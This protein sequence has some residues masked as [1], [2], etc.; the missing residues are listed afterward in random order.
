MSVMGAWSDMPHGIDVNSGAVIPPP[1]SSFFTGGYQPRASNGTPYPQF[2]AQLPSGVSTP[3]RQISSVLPSGYS[4]WPGGGG[5]ASGD[6][7]PTPAESFGL[8]SPA[9]SFGPRTPLSGY[10]PPTPLSYT[11]S[12]VGQSITATPYTLPGP[13]GSALGLTSSPSVDSYGYP[14]AKSPSNERKRRSIIRGGGSTSSKGRSDYQLWNG[15]EVYSLKNLA[16][17]PRDWRPDYNPRSGIASYITLGRHRSDVPEFTDTTKRSLNALLLYKPGEPA[18][19]WNLRYPPSN[20]N[21]VFMGLNNRPYNDID[22]VQLAT[23]P[24]TDQMRLYHPRLPWYIDVFRTHPNGVTI[25]DILQTIHAQLSTQIHQRHYYNEELDDA[26]RGV[27]SAA[28]N[29]RCGYRRE[30]TE[31]GILQ[32]DFLAYKYALMGL[33]KGKNGMWE[34][35]TGEED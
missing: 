17:R 3:A 26:H 10:I 32:V 29:D 21:V 7:T 34:M 31:R 23:S 5:G 19:F 2:G 4:Q 27:L 6:G 30:V 15:P 9:A 25:K 8:P 22:M 13:G 11:P 24:P 35:K 28:F 18:M 16:R 33:V 14:V 1:S 12:L 20:Q